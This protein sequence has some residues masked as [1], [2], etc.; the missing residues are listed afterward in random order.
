MTY[1]AFQKGL[2]GCSSKHCLIAVSVTITI[3]ALILGLALFTFLAQDRFETSA[4]IKRSTTARV[5]NATGIDNPAKATLS[6][7]PE[8][9]NE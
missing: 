3:F 8:P 7:T 6:D 1:T 9:N 5:V 2:A 4:R